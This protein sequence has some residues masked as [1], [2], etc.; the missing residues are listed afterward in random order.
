MLHRRNYFT[1]E[2]L[3]YNRE[4]MLQLRDYV[5]LG[6]IILHWIYYVTLE[7]LCYTG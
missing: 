3:C 2:R 6:E 4:I 5:P 7:R 1:L